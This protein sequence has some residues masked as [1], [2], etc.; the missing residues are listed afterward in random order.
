[1]DVVRAR[2]LDPADA[3]EVARVEAGWRAEQPR[4]TGFAMTMG[5]VGGAEEDEE[6]IYAL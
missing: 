6:A 4:L 1:M 3:R 5:R 2:D